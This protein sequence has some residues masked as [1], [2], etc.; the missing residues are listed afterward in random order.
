MSATDQIRIEYTLQANGQNWTQTVTNVGTGT[1]L[2][3]FNHVSGPMTGYG[4]GTEC[5]SGCTG[6][7]QQQE[8]LNT[9]ITLAAADTSFGGTIATAA[10][11]TYTGLESSQGGK[12]WTISK[13]LIP[14]ML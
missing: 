6:T 2:S 4:T 1:I 12:V 3:T 10:G 14:A 8:Y 11:A 5:D 9:E 7:S 13:M